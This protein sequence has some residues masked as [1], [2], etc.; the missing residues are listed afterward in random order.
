M[1]TGRYDVNIAENLHEFRSDY[2]AARESNYVRSRAGLAPLGGGADYHIRS[3]PT[4]LKFIERARDLCRNASIV[5]KSIEKAATNVVGDGFVL[6][7]ETGDS[8]A[9]LY[10]FEKWK[11]WSENRDDCDIAG[12]KSWSEM[13]ELAVISCI[14][15][16]DII[17]L[18]TTSGQLQIVESHQVRNPKGKR[19]EKKNAKPIIGVEINEYRKP[20]IYHIRAESVDPYR[21]TQQE[22]S[23]PVRVRDSN[24]VR[25][26]FHFF[27]RDRSSATRGVTALAPC[28]QKLAMFDDL[29]FAKL[30]QAQALSCIVVQR[31]KDAAR[32]GMPTRAGSVGLPKTEQQDSTQV[33][34]EQVQPGT[35]YD[36]KAGEKLEAFSPDV[37]NTNY[38]EHAKMLLTMFFLN[39]GLPY[40]MGMMD[41]SETNFS[42]WR[43][44]TDEAKKGFKRIQRQLRDKWHRPIYTWKVHQWIAED[45]KVKEI[46]DRIG[47]RIFKHTWGMPKWPY[48]QPVE[49]ATAKILRK[50]NMLSSPRRIHGEDSEDWEEIVDETVDDVAYAI[51]AAAIKA[52]ELTEELGLDPPLHW[53]ELLNLPIPDG[54][55]IAVN[56]GV[57]VTTAPAREGQ[58]NN[59]A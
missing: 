21:T 1:G 31:I 35:S 11:A 59:A 20:Q 37:P 19:G 7:P 49:D 32:A 57:P 17:G 41:A 28:F 4:Y 48:I 45:P 56:T 50:Q 54:L 16:G 15:D 3:E 29:D 34:I 44:A 33:S 12:E 18:G 43:A 39:I 8:E 22:E 24:G 40:V 26:L 52:K 27:V 55:Q 30:V 5:E 9:D 53:R 2:D 25:V 42:G 58:Q 6:R 10:L 38:F 47:D 13:E 14:R 36:N 46:Y 23:R 51:R